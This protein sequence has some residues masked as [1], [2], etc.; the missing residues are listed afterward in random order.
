MYIKRNISKVRLT[1]TIWWPLDGYTDDQ[2]SQNTW[3]IQSPLTSGRHSYWAGGCLAWDPAKNSNVNTCG[4]F[5]TGWCSKFLIQ[6]L[7]SMSNGLDFAANRIQPP[8]CCLIWIHMFFNSK[9]FKFY[10]KIVFPSLNTGLQH[11]FKPIFIHVWHLPCGESNSCGGIR[12]P[13]TSAVCRTWY[14][15][16]LGSSLYLLSQSTTNNFMGSCLAWKFIIKERQL[17]TSLY[18]L[19]RSSP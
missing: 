12:N 7:L 18:A 17:L 13:V 1:C 9:Q 6:C 15:Q 4:W 3:P 11:G 8:K 14:W 2:A 19:V 16:V 5:C 10:G